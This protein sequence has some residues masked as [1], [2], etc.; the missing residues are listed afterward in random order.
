[1]RWIVLSVLVALVLSLFGLW[2]SDPLAG[3]VA[4]KAIYWLIVTAFLSIEAARFFRWVH[5]RDL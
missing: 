3:N 4:P 2:V 1:M 5:D